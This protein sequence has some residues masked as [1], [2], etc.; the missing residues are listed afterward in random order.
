M[1]KTNLILS[2]LS[3]FIFVNS[4]AT[5]QLPTG[6]FWITNHRCHV[7]LCNPSEPLR[8]RHSL[9]D[10][11]GGPINKKGLAHLY[12]SGSAALTLA[13]MIWLKKTYGKNHPIYLIDL[14]QETHLYVND[15]PV[16]IY[17]KKNQINWD[18]NITQINA[19]ENLW[20]SQLRSEGKM[21]INTLNPP[22]EGLKRPGDPHVISVKKMQTEA[23]TAQHAGIQYHRIP[24]PDYHP[25]TPTQVDDYLTVINTLPAN[26]WV[27]VHCAA[28]KGRTTTFMVMRDIIANAKQVSLNDIVNRQEQLGGI[29]LL[30]KSASLRVLP[31]KNEYQEARMDYI[32]LFYHF[33]KSG[34]YPNKRFVDWV[35]QQPNS[36]YKLLLNSAAYQG[37]RITK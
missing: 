26:A 15:L 7:G 29:N 27:H 19:A 28:G 3:A 18:K 12:S 20:S 23:Q 9:S 6:A 16:S 10:P 34:A 30:R 22:Q 1:N 4:H 24:V 5:T 8:W 17:Y 25:P 32:R 33:V 21:V 2:L 11:I 35:A 31:W 37:E 14:R 13:N 36:P